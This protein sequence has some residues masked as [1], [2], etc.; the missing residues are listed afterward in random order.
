MP[1]QT[2][3]LNKKTLRKGFEKISNIVESNPDINI[4]VRFEQPK[5]TPFHLNTNDEDYVNPKKVDIIKKAFTQAK[6]SKKI[7]QW[8][9]G[10]YEY[11][12]N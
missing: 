4:V 1:T 2:L 3:E 9:K 6:K 8:D 10:F 11:L 12:S 5:D 7:F